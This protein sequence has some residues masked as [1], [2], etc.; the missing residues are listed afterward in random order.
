MGNRKTLTESITGGTSTVDQYNYVSGVYTPDPLNRYNTINTGVLGYDANGNMTSDGIQS[1]SYDYANRLVKVTTGSGSSQRTVGEYKYDALG[2]RVEKVTYQGGGQNSTTIR[3][4]YDGARCIEE[5]DEAGT[6][7][8]QYVYGNNIDEVLQMTRYGT[9]QSWKYYYHDN[10]LGSIYALTDNTGAIVE[11]YSYTAYGE[12]SIYDPSNPTEPPTKSTKGNRFMYT[13][14]EYDD[15]T[16]FYYYR[17]RYYSPTMGRFLQRDPLKND[18]LLNLYA[19]VANNP[20]NLIDPSG[21][22]EKQPDTGSSGTSLPPEAQTTI[23]IANP[24]PDVSA[25]GERKEQPEEALTTDKCWFQLIRFQPIYPA[26]ISIYTIGE[27]DDT[28]DLDMKINYS[29]IYS[30]DF[31]HIKITEIENWFAIPLGRDRIDGWASNEERQR[32]IK[33]GVLTD[34]STMS[35]RKSWIL[36]PSEQTWCVIRGQYIVK[37]ILEISGRYATTIERQFIMDFFVDVNYKGEYSTT[38]RGP[39]HHGIEGFGGPK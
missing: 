38:I 15:E 21:K 25:T 29:F 7:L 22:K 24:S 35:I 3:F 13:G 39:Q 16:G 34:Y 20:I 27:N 18:T 8:R 14:R 1:C 26:E 10:S 17:A 30:G 32:D 6:L 4:Y 36:P 19:Y 11:K 31:D 12:T 9:S 33:D 23:I 2:R 37:W 5:R 28:F